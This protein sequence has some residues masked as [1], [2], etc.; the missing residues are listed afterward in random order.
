MGRQ[1]DVDMGQTLSVRWGEA[2]EPGG[3]VLKLLVSPSTNPNLW[4]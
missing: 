1:I 3:K 4:S 2:A